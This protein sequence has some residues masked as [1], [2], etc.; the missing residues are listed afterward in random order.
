MS[1]LQIDTVALEII[2]NLYEEG[3]YNEAIEGLKLL[4]KNMNTK[5]YS[6]HKEGLKFINDLIKYCEMKLRK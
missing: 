6:N 2:N 5:K 4:K 3:K 1:A